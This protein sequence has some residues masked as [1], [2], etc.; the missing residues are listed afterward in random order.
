MNAYQVKALQ[1]RGIT[2][3]ALGCV[4]LDVESPDLS[5]IPD[6][7][8]YTSAHPDRKWISGRQD[9]GHVTL[10][11]GL[12]DNANTIREDIDEVLDGWTPG[13]IRGDR[14]T[15]RQTPRDH[16]MPGHVVGV[17]R[18][19]LPRRFDHRVDVDRRHRLNPD[20]ASRDHVRAT[21][22]RMDH[23]PVT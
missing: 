11:Y 22:R 9:E 21:H 10:L 18:H 6:E 14:L 1:R 8:C 15:D 12:L 4:M 13:I 17:L 5:C 20:S 7:W 16:R 23:H 19:Q 3:S 2:I